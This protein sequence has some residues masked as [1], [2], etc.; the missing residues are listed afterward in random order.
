MGFFRQEYWSGLPFLPPEVL[1]DPE[2]ES[3]SL[4][5]AAGSFTTEPVG[6]HSFLSL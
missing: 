2:I 5:L 4:A 6:E 1:P 3:L